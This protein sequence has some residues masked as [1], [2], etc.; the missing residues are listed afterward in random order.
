MRSV[1][2]EEEVMA[3]RDL[4][5]RGGL[6]VAKR[7]VD[8]RLVQLL[9]VDV[10]LAGALGHTVARQ[11]DQSLH[12]RRAAVAGA[13]LRRLRGR[14]E[15]DDLTALRIAEPECEPI[16]DHAV[17]VAALTPGARLRAV[18][19]RL[20]RRGRDPV[21]LGH[22]GLEREHED[23]CEDDRHDPVDDAAPRLRHPVRHLHGHQD[24]GRRPLAAGESPD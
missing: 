16:G 12:E 23:D 10:D 7:R 5:P 20:H 6:V 21:R 15:D 14:L 8:V 17:V 2:A 9:A 19:R 1:V 4:W 24:R 13:A 3:R 22:F 18:E 11:A